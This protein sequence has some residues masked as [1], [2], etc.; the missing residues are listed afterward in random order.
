MMN[1]LDLLYQVWWVCA[2]ITVLFSGICALTFIKN[3]AAAAVMA[4]LLVIVAAGWVPASI[5]VLKE[6]RKDGK[7]AKK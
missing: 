7:E 5:R 1:E 3:E 4:L 6:A 2:G